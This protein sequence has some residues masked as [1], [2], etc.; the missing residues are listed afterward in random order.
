MGVRWL[1]VRE[2]LTPVLTGL[3]IGLPASMGLSRLVASQLYQVRPHDPV[4]LGAV[5]SL[6]VVVSAVAALGPARRASRIDPA[7]ALRAE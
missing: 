2:A 6:L 7:D 3:A 1:V 5:V 4:T